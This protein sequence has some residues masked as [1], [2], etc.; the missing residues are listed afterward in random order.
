MHR[1]QQ[2]HRRSLRSYVLGVSAD[3][4]RHCPRRLQVTLVRSFGLLVVLV[5]LLIRVCAGSNVIAQTSLSRSSS[6]YMETTAAAF[7]KHGTPVTNLT[8][9][10][11]IIL[12]NGRSQTVDTFSRP[13]V[14][15][16]A[17]LGMTRPLTC[18]GPEPSRR[19][20]VL[21]LGKYII[22]TSRRS[23]CQC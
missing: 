2:L 1:L 6:V 5:T 8:K 12:E 23:S 16:T 20:N 9:D 15:Q 7:D 22:C 19:P 10:A 3:G 14:V 11:I 4:E 13:R 17:R 21:A 18:T